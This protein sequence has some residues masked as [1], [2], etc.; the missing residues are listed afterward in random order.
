MEYEDRQLEWDEPLLQLRAH[1]HR[2]SYTLEAP[3]EAIKRT[4]ISHLK[5]GKGFVATHALSGPSVFS[6]SEDRRSRPEL[7]DLLQLNDPDQGDGSRTIAAQYAK[8]PRLFTEPVEVDEQI[9]VFA[10]QQD[11][12]RE[13]RRSATSTQGSAPSP[14]PPKAW[15]PYEHPAVM[16]NPLYR[17][18]SEAA[19]GP[20]GLYDP[21]TLELHSG[22]DLFEPAALASPGVSMGLGTALSPATWSSRDGVPMRLSS[23]GNPSSRRQGYTLSGNWS[24]PGDST[25]DP[26]A[27]G[28][29]ADARQARLVPLRP[30]AGQPYSSK[31][32][33]A[34]RATATA[35][36]EEGAGLD[37]TPETAVSAEDLAALQRLIEEPVP[38]VLHVGRGTVAPAREEGSPPPP[39]PAPK[40]RPAA[41]SEDAPPVAVVAKKA[42]VPKRKSFDLMAMAS[43]KQGWKSKG[44]RDAHAKGEPVAHGFT[45][46]KGAA[47]NMSSFPKGP[48]KPKPEPIEEENMICTHLGNCRCKDCR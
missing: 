35:T 26:T 27:V 3:T 34:T 6:S 8:I 14:G 47:S 12:F 21:A 22:T 13:R 48:Y 44:A 42:H 24:Q 20:G 5:K 19:E 25:S 30:T 40:P 32:P 37:P 43:E 11:S 38:T 45:L 31:D 1:H 29:S 36:A 4:W 18:P 7:V 28:R 2:R 46:H 33:V 16:S 17:Q 23:T 10:S 15:G 9:T 39:Q 41:P